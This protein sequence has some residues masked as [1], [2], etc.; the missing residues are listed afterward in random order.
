MWFFFFYEANVLWLVAFRRSSFHFFA[1]PKHTL[2]WQQ[3]IT[4][5]PPLWSTW[6]SRGSEQQNKIPRQSAEGRVCATT[7]QEEEARGW[8]VV[9][10]LRWQRPRFWHG[11]QLIRRLSK[12]G[13]L[14]PVRRYSPLKRDITEVCRSCFC[15]AW[16]RSSSRRDRC[17]VLILFGCKAADSD[18]CVA[19]VGT[20]I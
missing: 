10:N 6:C 16:C 1:P 2:C 19:S 7:G 13:R 14:C 20:L 4:Q 15:S 8:A 9:N 17:D 3:N 11:R 5:A 12:G 18:V